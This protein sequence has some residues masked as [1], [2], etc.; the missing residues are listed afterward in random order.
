MILKVKIFEG[1]EGNEDDNN[2]SKDGQEGAVAS[3]VMFVG[4][5]VIFMRVFYVDCLS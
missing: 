4:C 2:D 3:K 5:C 1:N